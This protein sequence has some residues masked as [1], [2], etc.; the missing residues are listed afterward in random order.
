[1]RLPLLTNGYRS[2]VAILFAAL[3][4][5]IA[6]TGYLVF[7]YQRAAIGRDAEENLQAV[8]ELRSQQLVE[9][10]KERRVNTQM[11]ARRFFLIAASEQ[12]MRHGALDPATVA[13]F[14]SE[15][16]AL[17]ADYGF[18]AVTLL[19]RNGRPFLSTHE[20][21]AVNDEESRAT[22]KVLQTGETVV[23]DFHLSVDQPQHEWE[24]DVVAPVYS[25]GRGGAPIASLLVDFD[26]EKSLH[27]LIESWPAPSGSAETLLV[28][29][30][31]DSVAYL[32]D[33]RKRTDAQFNLQ[34]PMD[35]P[36]LIAAM[37][38]KGQSG[39]VQGIDYSGAEVLAVVRPISGTPWTL[40]AKVDSDEVYASVRTL[41]AVTALVTG[42]LIALSALI[43]I[44]WMRTHR[45][46]EGQ[47]IGFA[48]AADQVFWISEVSAEHAEKLSY[49]NAA[50]ERIWGFPA[51]EVYR[52][53][54]SRLDAV[55]PDDRGRVAGAYANWVRGSPGLDYDVSYR[56]IRPDG[57]MRW[58]ADR[59]FVL[60][61]RGGA[62][63]RVAG[64]AADISAAKR[65]EQLLLQANTELEARVAARTAEL[66]KSRHELRELT[67]MQDSMQE[68]QRKRIARE[69][70]DE[71]AQKLTVAKLQLKA[72]AAALPQGQSELI[73][74]TQDVNLLLTDT[75]RAAGQIAANLRSPVYTELGFAA[76]VQD[77]VDDFS[78][79]TRIACEFSMHPED[80]ILE[81]RVE[82]A[83]YRMIQESLTNVARHAQATEVVVSLFGAESGEIVLEVCDNG[84]GMPDT[85][86]SDARTFGLV[87]MRERAAILGGRMSISSAPGQGTTIEIVI[88][89]AGGEAD[90][91]HLS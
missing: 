27:P 15:Y 16:R 62:I 65:A 79:R 57:E 83:L 47:F 12:W 73:L 80:L 53:A 52:N 71:L 49:I 50:F 60:E 7:H 51:A 3:A 78:R 89:R 26:P 91:G 34:L 11:Q 68:E 56:I 29:R 18:R 69:L 66:E 14:K 55:H 40:V 81:S 37:A 2:F 17:S 82:A 75:M 72:I 19:D 76:A 67:A 1:M 43:T 41:A 8:A 35:Q 9:W 39:F 4:L 45:E 61:S 23:T 31:G 24:I 5:S 32:T 90:G 22:K 70:H 44:T 30:R 6:G 63:S 21:P 58:I 85:G 25:R 36:R 13:L 86:H 46:L 59:G 48:G 84:K 88:P 74:K 38:V 33:L 10:M 54:N 42:I 28:E 64:I 77:V 20:Q 87:G